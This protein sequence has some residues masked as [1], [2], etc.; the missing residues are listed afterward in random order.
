MRAEAA[1]VADELDLDPVRRQHFEQS[2]AILFY[3]RLAELQAMV[4]EHRGSA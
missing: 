1:R 3:R 2:R 4:S